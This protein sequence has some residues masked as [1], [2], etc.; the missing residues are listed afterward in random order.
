MRCA[1]PWRFSGAWPNAMPAFRRTGTRRAAAPVRLSGEKDVVAA[2]W[3]SSRGMAIGPSQKIPAEE[4]TDMSRQP[5]GQFTRR[6]FIKAAGATGATVY[7]I[8]SGPS[9]FGTHI[10]LAANLTALST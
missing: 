6:T 3:T 4:E 7:V 5:G 1:V 8:W 2:R 9:W 10:A